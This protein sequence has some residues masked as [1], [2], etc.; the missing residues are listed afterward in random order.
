MDMVETISK[1]KSEELKEKYRQSAFIAYLITG[2]EEGGF[3]EY[4]EK[5]GLNDKSSE[6]SPPVE[7]VDSKEEALSKADK[8]IAMFKQGFERGGVD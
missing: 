8:I 7:E 6:Q 1:V 2:G 5:I 4:L 3:A